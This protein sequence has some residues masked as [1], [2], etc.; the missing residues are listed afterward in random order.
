MGKKTLLDLGVEE[1]SSLCFIYNYSNMINVEPTDKLALKG[2]IY[3]RVGE[4]FGFDGELAFYNKYDLDS[5]NFMEY[6]DEY[7]PEDMFDEKA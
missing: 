7:V 3:R 4:V 2:N 5:P 1:G 6:E